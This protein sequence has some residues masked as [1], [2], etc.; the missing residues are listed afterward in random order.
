[1]FGT[2][3]IPGIAQ[4]PGCPNGYQMSQVRTRSR[5]SCRAGASPRQDFF[6]PETFEANVALKP[7]AKPMGENILMNVHLLG[8]RSGC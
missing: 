2:S 7:F 1:M 5:L 3:A 6:F 8:Y 4:I